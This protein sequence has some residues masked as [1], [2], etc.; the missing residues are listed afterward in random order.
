MIVE[1]PQMSDDRNDETVAQMAGAGAF[2]ANPRI[3]RRGA[4][5]GDFDLISAREF[6]A[7]VAE[8][9]Y[10]RFAGCET[11]GNA[12]AAFVLL[13]S[14]HDWLW[15]EQY[16]GGNFK[17][18]KE[19]FLFDDCPELAWARDIAEAAKH[20]DLNRTEPPVQVREVVWLSDQPSK[21]VLDDGSEHNIADVLLR[22]VA[23]FRRVHFP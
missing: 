8:P 20:R 16:V 13:W 17:I 5:E 22:I 10:E 3:V 9:A 19:Q 21:I 12:I 7:E 1:V 4:R 18:G 14:V 15:S 6:W 11:L 23:Y 2:G